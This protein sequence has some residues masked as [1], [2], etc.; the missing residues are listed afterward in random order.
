MV[1]PE[2]EVVEPD[3][4]VVPDP[5]VVVVPPVVVFVVVLVV[6][7]VVTAT[8]ATTA[9]AVT[10]GAALGVATLGTDVA[11]RLLGRTGVV[12]NA[13]VSTWTGLTA[14][15]NWPSPIGDDAVSTSAGV[16]DA[17]RRRR[18]HPRSRAG[19][20][21]SSTSRLGRWR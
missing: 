9:F 16:D 8:G 4:V 2:P 12:T 19:A 11:D 14:S 13:A 6:I 3:P 18:R 20:R 21:G 1:P 15:G 7:L 17:R 5:L 10:L